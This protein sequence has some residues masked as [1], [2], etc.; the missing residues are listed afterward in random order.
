MYKIVHRPTIEG[1]EAI[2]NQLMKQGYEP[3]GG[4]AICGDG[5]FFQA[6]VHAESAGAMNYSYD[7]G[8]FETREA[9]IDTYAGGYY[10]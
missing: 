2:V 5:V 4:V 1:L 8:D 6:L 3:I 7:Y 10:K 9:K